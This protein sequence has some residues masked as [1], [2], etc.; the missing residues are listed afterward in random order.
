[1]EKLRGR[2]LNYLREGQHFEPELAVEVTDNL[3]DVVFEWIMDAADYMHGS[4]E[5]LNELREE[6]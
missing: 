5:V 2:I 1:M 3:I 6:M 4:G